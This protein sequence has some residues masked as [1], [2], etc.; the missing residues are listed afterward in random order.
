VNWR[1]IP[2]IPTLLVLAASGY[3]VHLGLWQLDRL[4]QKQ[5]RLARYA[6]AQSDPTPVSIGYIGRN[7]T[8][9]AWDFHHTAFW[10]QQVFSTSM[11]SGRNARGQTGWVQVAR[12]LTAPVP[13]QNFRPT[14][15]PQGVLADVVLGWQQQATPVPW[16]GGQIRGIIAPGGEFHHHVV[17]NPPLAGLQ[18]NAAPDPKDVPNN[19]FSYAVQWFL[20]ATVALVIYA[21]ALRARWRKIDEA[22]AMP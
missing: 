14:Q 7:P 2:L 20:F 12:C 18:A 3:M 9:D 17:A 1:R 4:A 13:M 6:A 22:L 16:A 11:V 15:T 8:S 21:L 19:H 5:A 10:C